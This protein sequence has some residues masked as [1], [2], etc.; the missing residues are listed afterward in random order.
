VVTTLVLAPAAGDSNRRWV[1][2][3]HA[4][5]V[6]TACTSLGFLQ[7]L[8]AGAS[9]PV[10]LTVSATA[11]GFLGG[12]LG[13]R[14]RRALFVAV[15]TVVLT[16]VLIPLRAG[17]SGG[18]PTLEYVWYRLRF[19]F[20]KPASA[21]LLPPEIRYLWSFEHAPPSRYQMLVFLLPLAF[22][23]A[24]AAMTARESMQ[25]HRSA[26]VASAV[27]AV[28][29]V[30]VY[31]VDR[32]ALV[33]AAVA[34]AP[35]VALAGRG[36]SSALRSRGV[37]VG[38]GAFI[39][40]AQITFPLGAVNPAFQ[41]AKSGGFAH[42]DTSRFLWVSMEN[43]ERQLVRFVASRTSVSDAFLGSPE[44]TALLLTFA[45]R[46]SVALGGAVTDA[47]ATRNANLAHL[48][49]EDE[50]A[51]YDTC[52]EL[53]VRYVLYS[54]DYLL[55]TTRYSPA[56]LAAVPNVSRESAAFRMHFAPE[57]LRR[58]TLVYENAH[59]RLFRVTETPGTV[60]LTDHPPV[61]Q[62]DAFNRV[63]G[64]VEAFRQR[65]VELVLAYRE[66]LRARAMGNTAGALK[67]LTW[68][69]E[70]APDFTLAR[71][72]LG[73]TLIQA[74]RLEEARDVLLS[75]I[76]YA[77][78]NAPALYHTAYVLAALDETDRAREYLDVFFAVATDPDLIE[79]A[80]LLKTFVEQ[81]IPVTPRAFPE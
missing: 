22:F 14:A 27:V 62:I 76:G 51:L 41:I 70:Q 21:S 68:C 16:V 28:A 61:Y 17:A 52:R 60:F 79:K 23:A 73:T 25:R 11:A 33:V 58:F 20:D 44:V 26:F 37:L 35:F 2:A 77:P 46:T 67:T 39:I 32:S 75:V 81:G 4:V 34:V 74:G 69:L 19:L 59:Y 50:A 80:R 6:L 53:D 1:V 42:R 15:A 71:V 38:I 40:V 8:H 55:D 10:A 30:G 18:V 29:A 7:E 72:A 3:A 5:A 12:R 47:Y 63:G 56:Y 64:N 54:I 31:L 36:I 13:G 49:Y 43:T 65:A 24:A 45:G 78:D 9:W 48:L 66:A 57:S